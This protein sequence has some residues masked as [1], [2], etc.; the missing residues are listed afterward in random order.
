MRDTHQKWTVIALKK[1]KLSI[2]QFL[3]WAFLAIPIELI[4]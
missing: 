1:V 4:A 2:S 3:L